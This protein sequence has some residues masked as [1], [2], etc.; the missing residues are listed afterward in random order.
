MQLSPSVLNTEEIVAAI[1]AGW[2]SLNKKDFSNESNH[3]LD[4]IIIEDNPIE[5]SEL[6][7][8]KQI[9]NI[10]VQRN[11]LLGSYS[12]MTSPG[13][14]VVHLNNHVKLAQNILIALVKQSGKTTFLSN[15]V[16]SW[17]V[18]G[19]PYCL[20]SLMGGISSEFIVKFFMKH[21]AASA[22]G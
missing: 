10:D 15:E 11:N 16:F 5:V 19:G 1:E 3:D 22:N 6:A 17:I 12:P 21:Q 18:G 4:F 20:D 9:E 2:R 8:H 13:K 14:I 7:G